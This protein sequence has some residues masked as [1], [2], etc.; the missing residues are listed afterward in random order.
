MRISRR[1]FVRLAG[2]SAAAVA[3]APWELAGGARPAESAPGELLVPQASHW[4][5]FY[6]RVRAG[7][8]VEAVPYGFDPVPRG[9]LN[10]LPGWVYAAN[11]VRAP[12]VRE[13]FLAKRSGSDRTKRGADPFVRVSWDEAIKLVADELRRVKSQYGATAIYGGSYGWSSVGVIHKPTTALKRFLALNG[14]FVDDIGDYSTGAAQ[15]ILPHVLGTLEVYEQQTVWPQILANT[16]LIVLWGADPLT[17]NAIDW[18]VPDHLSYPYYMQAKQ[19]GIKFIHINPVRTD[20]AETLGGQW[21]AP[22][23]NTDPALMLGMAY[24]L[25]AEHRVNEAFLAKYAVGYDRLQSYVLGTGDNQ[26]KTPDWAAKI[27]GLPASAI[28]DLAHAIS[29]QRTMLMSGWGPQRQ[30]HGEQ[31]PWMLVAL[32]AMTGQFGSPGGGAGFSYHYSSGG[33]PAAGAPLPSGLGLVR[34]PVSTA[35]PVA[36]WVDMLLQPGSTIDFNG[37]KITYPDIKLVYWAGGN[38]FTH[39]QDVNRLITAW[40]RPET[41]I[42]NDAW[43]TPTAKFADIVLPAATTLERN[44]L[45]AGGFYA[46]RYLVAMVKAI[47]PLGES[48]GDY[49]IFSDLAQELGFRAQYTEGRTDLQ[50]VQWAYGNAKPPGGVPWFSGS[51]S[52]GR[53][54]TK[55]PAF[56][57]F[58][59]KGILVFQPPASSNQYVRY[60]TF[61][62]D[63]ATNP[64]GTP[65][66]K[67]ELY[68]E[69]IAKLAY[70]DCPPHPSW[71][72]PAEWL[73]SAKA[74]QYPFHLVS[75]HPPYRLHSQLDQT[76]T[77][78]TQHK[79]KGRQVVWINPADAASRGIHSG[80]IVRLYNGRGAVLASA[81]VTDRVRTQVVRLPEGGWYDPAT[82]GGPGSLDKEGSPNT[83]TLDIGT[84][85]LAQGNVAHTTLVQVE[86]YTGTLS[87]VTAYASPAVRVR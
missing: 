59:K 76:A 65:S 26:P 6:A 58:W 55:L 67:I 18:V 32:A 57:D 28:V 7:K 21:I 56:A 42:V 66:G 23:P 40:Q 77:Q 19:R 39:H 13:S 47:E 2:S 69:T 80:D 61:I 81:E 62:A 79:G 63:P 51:T 16:K 5:G 87:A 64:L 25:I 43:W 15:V 36:R 10:Q 35:I 60:A 53:A 11:R 9:Y 68:S 54:T 31:A 73:G 46:D 1:D 29:S 50:W 72:E 27:T 45:D 14:G 52:T 17:T 41:I 78:M 49:D 82:P 22:R 24:V 84:S 4:G 85:K 83:L 74:A 30:H 3:V 37:R 12:M 71:L 44:D 34:N 86:K 48:R 20:S 33:V 38:P 75:P 70:A 8:F